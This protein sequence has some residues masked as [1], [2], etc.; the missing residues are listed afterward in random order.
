MPP[1]DSEDGTGKMVIET[2]GNSSPQAMSCW[3]PVLDAFQ[4][5]DEG[6]NHS[7]S[8]KLSIPLSVPQSNWNGN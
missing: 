2:Y 4:K 8:Q 5:H 7:R 6:G 3:D 1:S